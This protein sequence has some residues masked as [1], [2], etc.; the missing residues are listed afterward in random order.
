MDFTFDQ[1]SILLLLVALLTLFIWGKWRYD[2]VAAAGLFAAVLLGLVPAEGAFYGFGHPATI[3]VAAVLVLSRALQTS[4][5]V[6]GIATLVEKTG[7]SRFAHITVLVGVAAFLSAFMNNVGALALLMPV[8]LQSARKL[9]RSPRALLMPLSFGSILGGLV[10]LIGTPPNILV[11]TYR[12]ELVGAPFSMFDFTPVGGA[13]AIVGLL[14]LVVI[15]WRLIPRPDDPSPAAHENF[16]IAAYLTEVKVT[17]KSPSIGTTVREI[18]KAAETMEAQIIGFVRGERRYP[19]VPRHEPLREDDILIIEAPPEEIDKFASKFSLELAGQGKDVE[20]RLAGEDTEI[21]EVVVAP[22]SVL[23]GRTVAALRLRRRYGVT[24]LGVS[25]QGRPFGG[26]L[27]RFRFQTGDVLMLQGLSDEVGDAV[28]RLGCL[29]LAG[30]ELAFGKR[31]KAWATLGIFAL[32]VAASALGYVSIS[33]AFLGAIIATV[34]IN[35]TAPRDLYSAV[36]WPVIVLLGALIPI[37]TAMDDTGT[38]QL[39][40]DT[41]VNLT[42]GFS[43]MWIIAILLVVT[44]TLSDVLNNA[45]TAVVMAPIAGAVAGS[46]NLSPD[47]FLM[48][49]AVGASCAF[50]TPIGH[51]NNALVMGPAGYRFSDYW[52]VGLPLEVLIAVVAVPLIMLVFPLS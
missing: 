50:L 34:L 35:V 21:V 10:T 22:G 5:A 15:G 17:E 13:V 24:L 19:V 52:R 43:P 9:E 25:R 28:S 32:A 41:V 6:D 47:P 29:P 38:T 14:F 36:D 31:H 30:R 20:E 49:V 3:T 4:G 7:S 11:A 18:E 26:R 23:E 27:R 45:A 16:D 51:Q 2:V 40:A 37:G 39:I 48:A 12:E 44:M 1:A 46:L 42:T 33:V 8:A